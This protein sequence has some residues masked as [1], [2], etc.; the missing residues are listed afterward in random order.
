MMIYFVNISMNIYAINLFFQSIINNYLIN[1]LF[2][3]LKNLFNPIKIKK[4]VQNFE[5]FEKVE[6]WAK[7]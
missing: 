4:K 7:E 1:I 5:N 2:L 6:C 3:V